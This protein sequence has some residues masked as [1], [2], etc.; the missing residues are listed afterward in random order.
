ML[1]VDLPQNVL[2]N[3]ST[4][5]TA[6]VRDLRNRYTSLLSWIGAGEEII[7]TQRGKAVARLI[8]ERAASARRVDWSQS[9]AVKRDRS[10]E[11]VLTAK[12]SAN[13]LH[14]AGGKW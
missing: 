1:K 9:P 13:L 11:R 14:D 7:I 12:E 3:W 10:G 2:H 6:T 4:M 5:K 8:P